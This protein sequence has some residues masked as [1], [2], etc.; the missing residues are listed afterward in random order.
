MIRII[1]PLIYTMWFLFFF[2]NNVLIS[3]FTIIYFILVTPKSRACLGANFFQI[4][5]SDNSLQRCA[6]LILRGLKKNRLSRRYFF[7]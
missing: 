5:S 3:V 6:F 7:H 4:D 2:L 1:L